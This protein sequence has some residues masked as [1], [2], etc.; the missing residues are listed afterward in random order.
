MSQLASIDGDLTNRPHYHMLLFV[1]FPL[2]NVDMKGILQGCWPN[3]AVDIG[4]NFSDACTNY[5]AKHQVKDCLGS[6]FQNKVSP[7]FKRVSR[8]KGGIGVN[9]MVNDSKIVNLFF[10]DE[11]EKSID[12][13]QGLLKFKVGIPRAVRRKLKPRKLTLFE[14]RNL[15]QNSKDY[16]TRYLSNFFL[17]HPD[18]MP[19]DESRNCVSDL[20]RIAS[21]ESYLEDYERKKQHK[22]KRLEKAA[23]KINNNNNFREGV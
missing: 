16:I 1:P 2:N 12:L 5:I 8:Y 23:E 6:Q 14:L 21:Y 4:E 13:Q 17:A 18:S 9:Q 19:R 3:G 20:I 7:I 22:I 15:E 11:K 10:D